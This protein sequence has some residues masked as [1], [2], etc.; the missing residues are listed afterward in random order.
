MGG[1]ALIP[2]RFPFSVFRHDTLGTLL[3]LAG[4]SERLMHQI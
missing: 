1:L 2:V 3:N 4:V